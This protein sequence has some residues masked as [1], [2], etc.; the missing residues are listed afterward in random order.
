MYSHTLHLFKQLEKNYTLIIKRKRCVSL[1]RVISTNKYYINSY[2]LVIKY[3]YTIFVA[4]SVSCN[5]YFSVF[6][7][8]GNEKNMR[9]N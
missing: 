8:F 5:E 6:Y 4:H 7:F 1:I 2:K 3:P 9:S